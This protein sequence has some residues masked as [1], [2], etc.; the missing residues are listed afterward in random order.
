MDKLN[1]TIAVVAI[2]ITIFFSTISI[3]LTLIAAVWRVGLRFTA[4]EKEMVGFREVML[5][6]NRRIERIESKIDG[7]ELRGD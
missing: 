1:V 5:A 2:I 4:I 3:V 7:N 6:Q